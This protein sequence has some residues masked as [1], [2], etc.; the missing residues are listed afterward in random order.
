MNNILLI[1][2]CKKGCRILYTKEHQ[3]CYLGST[4]H[5]TKVIEKIMM[6]YH[7]SIIGN[8]KQTKKLFMFRQKVPVFIDLNRFLFFPTLSKKDKECCWI[9]YYCVSNIK[10]KKERT[11]VSFCD[12]SVIEDKPSF[13][14]EYEC[15]IDIRVIRKQM[16]RCYQIHRCYVKSTHDLIE[17]L[18]NN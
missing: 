2:G 4:Q 9:N 10:K 8:E 12:Y 14:Y 5:P 18:E 16:K 3:L 13:L 15:P 17:I 6:C 7:R 1:A 11:L